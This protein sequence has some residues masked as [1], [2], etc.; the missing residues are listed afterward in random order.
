MATQSITFKKWHC[1]IFR[2]KDRSGRVDRSGSDDNGSK[3]QDLQIPQPETKNT[4]VVDF[5]TSADIQ[6][7]NVSDTTTAR[8]KDDELTTSKSG[9]ENIIQTDEWTPSP[10]RSEKTKEL[11]SFSPSAEVVNSDS[12]RNCG[13]T[14]SRSCYNGT[15]EEI[16]PPDH[17]FSCRQRDM[18]ARTLS[19]SPPTGGR[20]RYQRRGSCTRWS[21]DNLAALDC[22]SQNAN[23]KMNGIKRNTSV[24][25]SMN[26]AYRKDSYRNCASMDST[27]MSET[28]VEEGEDV[29]FF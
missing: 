11:S 1:N 20:M 28:I 24:P 8:T 4:D 6:S 5:A 22:N 15:D 17:C 25:S 7:E 29:M 14:N 2:R 26:S 18:N 10:D 3:C 9:S 21:F 16:V 19:S 12:T 27:T 13:E 23:E